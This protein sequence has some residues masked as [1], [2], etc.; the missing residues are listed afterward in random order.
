LY[1]VTQ[2][3][4]HRNKA[5]PLLASKRIQNSYEQSVLLIF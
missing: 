3:S 2:I 5:P 4:K 1:K